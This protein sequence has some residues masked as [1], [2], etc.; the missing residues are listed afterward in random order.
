MIKG[1]NFYRPDTKLNPQDRSAWPVP[2]IDPLSCVKVPPC[3]TSSSSGPD[4]RGGP[5]PFFPPPRTSPPW[6]FKGPRAGGVLPQP[7]KG[8]KSPAFI[9]PQQD[10]TLSKKI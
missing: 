7:T 2:C 4:R 10:P 1:S 5:P 8:G 6:E 9:S 3:V